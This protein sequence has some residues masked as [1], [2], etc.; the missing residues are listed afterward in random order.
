M[1]ILELLYFY[2][3]VRYNSYIVYINDMDAYLWY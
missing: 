3:S 2:I 1:G